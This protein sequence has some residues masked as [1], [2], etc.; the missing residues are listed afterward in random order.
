MTGFLDL[1]INTYPTGDSHGDC[2]GQTGA[3]IMIVPSGD[4]TTTDGITSFNAW[5]TDNYLFEQH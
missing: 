5:N 3:K 4:L 1:V 2:L